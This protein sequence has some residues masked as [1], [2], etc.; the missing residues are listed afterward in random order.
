MAA[1][2]PHHRLPPLSWIVI[3][4]LLVVLAFVYSSWR[5]VDMATSGDA[6]MIGGGGAGSPAPPSGGG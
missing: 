1:S 4:G 2:D 6:P 3:A 5:G